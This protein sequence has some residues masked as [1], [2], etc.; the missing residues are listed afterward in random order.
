M[1]ERLLASIR[2]EVDVYG[3]AFRQSYRSNLSTLEVACALGEPLVPW[4]GRQI[5]KLV[6]RATSEPN[7]YSGVYGLN[8]FPF[9]TDL[10]NWQMPPRY[11]ILR[12]VKGY[13]DLPTILIDGHCMVESIGANFLQRAIVRPRRPKEGRFRLL[14]IYDAVGVDRRIR[15][16]EVF[17]EPANEFAVMARNTIRDWLAE[18]S[19]KSI[20]L[21]Q[22]NDTLILDNW[23]ILHARSPIMP[24]QLDREIE[25]VY[26]RTMQ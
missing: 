17:L 6:P 26:L 7:T 24:N 10:A 25:R 18:S 4:E 1:R 15:W 22:E 2:E 20:A 13:R 21:A 5:Q 11:L 23:R 16:D 14:Q 8:Q 9:H 12:C 19:P 3:F